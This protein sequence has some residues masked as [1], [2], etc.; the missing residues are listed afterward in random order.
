MARCL[1]RRRTKLSAD[2]QLKV[3]IP[4]SVGRCSFPFLSDDFVGGTLLL[5]VFLSFFLFC[6]E[7]PRNVDEPGRSVGPSFVPLGFLD[8][9]KIYSTREYYFSAC[10]TGGRSCCL[11]C[12]VGGMATQLIK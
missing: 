5:L 11:L 3:F 9:I 2:A 8:S 6:F 7:I 12:T 10:V 4:F 1:S